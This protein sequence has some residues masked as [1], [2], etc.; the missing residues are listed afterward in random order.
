VTRPRSITRVLG[1]GIVGL[2]LAGGLGACGDKEE[3]R[4][5]VLA[6]LRRTDTLSYKFVYVDDRPAATFPGAPPPQPD[7]EVQGLVQDDFRFKAR[8]AMNKVPSFDEVVDDDLLA[9]RF[10]EPGR[11][12]PLVN[13]SKLAEADTKTDVEGVDSLAAL[14]S[15]RWVIDETAAP[16][17]TVGRVREA[18][19]G[20][21]P[22]LDSITVL[23]YVEAAIR[24]AFAV[25]EYSADDVAPAY[26]SSEDDFPKPQEHSGVT[27]YDLRRPKLPPPGQQAG[28]STNGRPQ[29]RHFRRMSI[30]VK[31]GRVIQVREAVDVKGRFLKDVLKYAKTYAKV[32]GA[33]TKDIAEFEAAIKA[34]PLAQQGSLVL[35][36]LSLAL[37]STGDEP[38][39]QRRMTLDLRDLGKVVVVDLPTQDVVKGGLGYLIVT[40]QGKV[41]DE[42]ETSGQG[43]GAPSGSGATAES[44]TTSSP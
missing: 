42:G 18:S 29:T 19:L 2:V 40:A 39:L 16:S 15:R 32:S 35:E 12:E 36:G 30:Y 33:S 23:T 22:V 17:V 27:R 6:A 1:V 13:K 9:M 21:D 28:L 25:E 7:I 34:A 38:I 31:D 37:S 4:D 26:S 43:D 20:Q 8:V 5:E 11:L 44:T 3:L 41:E 10:L 24:E 14:Q